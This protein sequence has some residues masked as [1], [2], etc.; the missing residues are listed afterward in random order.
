MPA[1]EWKGAQLNSP[2]KFPR[3]AAAAALVVCTLVALSALGGVGSA[4]NGGNGA[5]ASQYQYGAKVTICH[6]G[7]NTIT[8]GKAA[9]PAH[10]RHGDATGTCANVAAKK[11][12]KAKAAKSQ[13]Q[14]SQK[15]GNG[16]GRGK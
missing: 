4:Q 6:K 15:P 8:V 12:A 10:L 14:E 9:V 7:K 1:T 5:S 11:A 3:I 16:K 2:R 13:A